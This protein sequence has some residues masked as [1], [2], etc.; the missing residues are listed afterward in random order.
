VSA[1][2]ELLA[3]TNVLHYYQK[4]LHVYVYQVSTWAGAWV[5]SNRAGSIQL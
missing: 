5:V 3:I 4:R 1:D 2:S